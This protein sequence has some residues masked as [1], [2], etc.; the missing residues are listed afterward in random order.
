LIFY[1]RRLGQHNNRGMAAGLSRLIS[2]ARNMALRKGSCSKS[3]AKN[4]DGLLGA[5]SHCS[6]L[7]GCKRSGSGR[8][9]KPTPYHQTTQTRTGARWLIGPLLLLTLAG[10]AACASATQ[11]TARNLTNGVPHEYIIGAGDALEILV[12]KNT[13]LSRTV[14]VRPDGKISLPLINDVQAAGLTPM[15]LK[16]EIAQ[17]LKKFKEV[18]EVSV[19]VI[20]A[21]S[22]VVY[23]I[24]QV[25]RPGAYPLGPNATVIQVI[26][27]A[28][29]FTPFADSN[30]IVVL[31]RGD[32]P[33][34][35]QRIEVSYKA[36]LKGQSKNGDIALQAGDTVVVP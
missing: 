11:N 5:W 9:V 14:T 16:D 3:Y 17:E 7:S 22:R 26:S 24:G 29:G 19:I 21:K 35:E 27:L 10:A 4:Y 33:S 34:K 36:I 20:D 2:M 28:G 23:I 15:A 30:N 1:N 12:W 18:P 25:A 8:M 32:G 31:R 6:A 13:D